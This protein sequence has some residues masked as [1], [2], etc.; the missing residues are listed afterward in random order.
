MSEAIKT[1][2]L[3]CDDACDYGVDLNGWS[4][5]DEVELEVV[6]DLCKH[7]EEIAR[8]LI[9]KD[10]DRLV[11]GLCPQE[12]AMAEIQTQTRK[13]GL[14]PFGV[15]IIELQGISLDRAKI[16]L[17]AAAAR[18]MAYAGSRPENAKPH[19]SNRMS[20]RSLFK[21]SLMEY[22]AAPSIEESLCASD[23]GCQVCVETCPHDALEWSEGRIEYDKTKCQICG[24]CVTA[25]P[26]G[27]VTNPTITPEQLEAE[28]KTTLDPS[29]DAPW[30]RG[31]FYTCRSAPA[32]RESYHEGWFP[33]KVPCVGMVRPSW[34]LAPLVMGAGE[35]G[36]TPCGEGCPNGQDRAI[37]ETVSYCSEFLRLAGAPEGCLN[38]AQ[39][40]DGPPAEDGKRI[41]LETPF[42]HEA[43]PRVL[44]AL[45]QKYDTNSILL[46][47]SSSPL[48]IIEINSDVC[49]GCGR[50][51]KSCPTGA[52]LYD[53]GEENISL[54]F[55]AT[56]CVACAGCT[57]NCPEGERGAIS[58]SKVTDLGHLGRGRDLI[59]REDTTRCVSCGGA[60][61]SSKMMA[62]IEEMLGDDFAATSDILKRYCPD[63]RSRLGT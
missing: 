15:E 42:S 18:A 62:R 35:V 58:L 39:T 55:D 12:Y 31:V 19:L 22:R 21:L 59:Y 8:L 33:I 26:T 6:P 20:R 56:K 45:A 11:L 57:P 23:L 29:I 7:P 37:E 38:L 61:A 24:L 1:A 32:S 63:C 50:C 51:A 34:L 28:V 60:I 25:C 9:G 16:I 3:I 17:A 43:T 27:A 47:H 14:D 2:I 49:T 36:I 10:V 48:G 30:P 13:S 5:E 46:E 54:T 44:T 41:D 4:C 52:L 53:E 40:L